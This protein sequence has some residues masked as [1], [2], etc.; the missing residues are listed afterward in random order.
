M[1][2]RTS[3]SNPAP[4][5]AQHLRTHRRPLSTRLTKGMARIPEPFGREVLNAGQT[6]TTEAVTAFTG[7]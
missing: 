5:V 3:N 7:G 6:S 4:Q 1:T 2:P